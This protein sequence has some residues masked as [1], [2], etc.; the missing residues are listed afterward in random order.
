MS[1]S[2]RTVTAGSVARIEIGGTPAREKP[3]FWAD[4]DSGHP[5]ASIADLMTQEV[6]G[7]A[8]YISDLGVRSSNVKLVPARTPIMSF[9]LSIGR[10]ALAGRD[11]YTNEAIAAFFVNRDEVDER[12][13]FHVLP[14]SARAVITDVAIKGATLNKKSLAKMPLLLP[15]LSEQRWIADVLDL[16]SRGI[17]ASEQILTKLRVTRQAL[18]QEA[19]GEAEDSL[20]ALGDLAEVR[21]GSTPSRTRRDYWERGSVPWLASGKV[22]DYRITTPSELVTQRAVSECHLRV[23]PAGSVLVGMIG[24]GKTRGM[25]ARLDIAA[26]INQNLAGIV[27]G[28]RLLGGY[29]HHYLAHSY[30]RLRSGGRGSNQDAL[31]TGLVAA[32]RV[33]VPPIDEQRR[34]MDLLDALDLRVNAEREVVAKLTAQ[35]DGLLAD[36]LTG[37]IRVPTE[38]AS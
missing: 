14:G 24:Q 22:N 18:Y 6:V 20:V 10:T 12:F 21:N 5:W 19:F 7:T 34:I 37:R 36:L 25:A 29:L 15:P 38:V 28:P 35:K 8:E 13:L 3:Q 32:F 30:Q 1:D 2:W 33:P 16:S 26:A 27:P 4:Q 17:E 31:T 9:K 11:L 23:L